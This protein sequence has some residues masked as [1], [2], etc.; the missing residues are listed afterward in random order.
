MQKW[1][2]SLCHLYMFRIFIVI[3]N[4]S[5]RFWYL[6]ALTAYLNQIIQLWTIIKKKKWS[7]FLIHILGQLE[8]EV[9][10]KKNILTVANLSS[11]T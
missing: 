4:S 3:F 7:L 11:E 8:R 9:V 10:N 6:D 2:H 1:V 5:H